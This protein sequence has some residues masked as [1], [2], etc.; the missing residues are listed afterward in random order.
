MLFVSSPVP[1]M[2]SAHQLDLA[3]PHVW[4]HSLLLSPSSLS[5][6]PFGLPADTLP[7]TWNVL[8][9]DVLMTYPPTHPLPGG[10]SKIAASCIW[11]F[12]VALPTLGIML[13]GRLFACSLFL[14]PLW[15]RGLFL[16]CSPPYLQLLAHSRCSISTM[17]VEWLERMNGSPTMQHKMRAGSPGA[18]NYPLTA[19]YIQFPPWTMGSLQMPQRLRWQIMEF[20]M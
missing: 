4:P 9:P 14:S 2:F 16:L 1:S 20:C 8:P 13:Q 11:F 17:S 12:F 19:Q 7:S 3:E 10:T 6:S 15:G 5:S 18:L